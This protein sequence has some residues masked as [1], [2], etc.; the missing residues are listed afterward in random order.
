MKVLTEKKINTDTFAGTA[1]LITGID[2]FSNDIVYNEEF[3]TYKLKGK[4]IPS[5]TQLLDDGSLEFVD[6]KILKYAQDKGTLVHKEIEWWFKEEKEGFTTEFYNFLD[7]F[8][9]NKELFEGKAIWDY[10]TFNQCTP[11]KRKKCYKQMKMYSQGIEY[12]TGEKITQ[13]YMIWLP[14]NKKGKILDLT[15]EFGDD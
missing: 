9:E 15:K 5:V 4:I 13:F 3:H 12:L 7:L 14:S 2:D 8:N 11:A 1:D 6:E 10:K